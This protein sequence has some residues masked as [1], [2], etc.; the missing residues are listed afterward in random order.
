M[1]NTKSI[2]FLL[3]TFCLSVFIIGCSKESSEEPV[4]DYHLSAQEQLEENLASLSADDLA[5]LDMLNI[6]PASLFELQASA[7]ASIEYLGE[8]CSDMNT[9]GTHV[10]AA[11]SSTDPLYWQYYNFSGNAGDVVTL[12][13]QR[14]TPD[15]DPRSMLFEGLYSDTGDLTFSDNIANADDNVDDPFGS[16]FGDPFIEITLPSDGDYTFAV[17]EFAS[18]GNDL[19]YEIITT[20]ISCDADGDGCS[21]DEDPHPNSIVDATII[22]DGC[23]TGVANI[24]VS[25]D[26]CSTMSDL[27]MDLA[28]NAENHGQF[29]SAVAALTNQWKKDGIIKGSEKGA[30]QSCAGQS[31]L[32]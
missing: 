24:F 5:K 12:Y 1:Q 32:P 15:L 10:E 28:A 26:G 7:R 22:I 30:I 3:L 4:S 8:L 11:G 31:N 6:D 20:G 9:L 27:I 17:G 13:V 25:E 29:V 21:D 19:G 23:D 16:C 18:C 14:T 2:Y